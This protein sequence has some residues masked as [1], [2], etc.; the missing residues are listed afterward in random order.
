[1]KSA[2]ET[3]D[4][5]G[6]DSALVKLHTFPLAPETRA[7]VMNIAQQVF[8]GDFKKA[9]ETAETLIGGGI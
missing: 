7:T 9:A 3:E 5:E 4:T 8:L 6:M 1:L 2:L